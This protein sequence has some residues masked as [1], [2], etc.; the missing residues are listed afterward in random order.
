MNSYRREHD[1][2]KQFLLSVVIEAA[3]MMTGYFVLEPDADV[4]YEELLPLAL[5]DMYVERDSDWSKCLPQIVE[6]L[7]HTSSAP[8]SV[9]CV[10]MS[11]CVLCLRE[12]VTHAHTWARAITQTLLL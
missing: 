2:E 6:W 5:Y 12:H 3:V 10:C 4:V 7:L 8:G 1:A 9:D 11:M